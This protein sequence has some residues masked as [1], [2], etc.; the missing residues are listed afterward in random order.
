MVKNLTA[1]RKMV[2]IGVDRRLV[3]MVN[4]DVLSA[5]ILC[6]YRGHFV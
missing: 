2:E 5:R 1:F 3:K 6:N 4:L